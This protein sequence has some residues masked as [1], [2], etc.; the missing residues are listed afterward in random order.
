MVLV[1]AVKVMRKDCKRV[2]NRTI[3]NALGVHRTAPVH[4]VQADMG[5]LRVK[6]EYYL[7]I[8]RLWNKLITVSDGRISQKVAIH[9][10]INMHISNWFGK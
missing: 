5:W 10:L 8:I 9:A 3:R 4:A 2:K 6:Y 1:V 7:C